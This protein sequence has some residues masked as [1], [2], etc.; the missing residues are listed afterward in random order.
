MSVDEEGIFKSRLPHID[1]E[2]NN[3]IE[4][5]IQNISG[6]EI[7][8][9]FLDDEDYQNLKLAFCT[10]EVD[11]K[12]NDSVVYSDHRD[13]V[14]NFQFVHTIHH[15][16]EFVSEW[17]KLTY[18]ILSNLKAK[19]LL[20]IKANLNVRTPT[21]IE[22]KYHND[23][24]MDFIQTGYPSFPIDTTDHI[25]Y[26]TAIYYV[27]SNDGYTLFECGKKIE[28]VSNRIVIFPGKLKHAGTTCTNEKIRVV[29]NINYI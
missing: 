24:N 20:R 27:N 6:I 29:L 12:W 18:P 25:P 19:V 11:W 21:I 10:S 14:Y 28:S 2:I 23:M 3:D 1:K 5:G 4:P 26:K 22:R 15:N 9:N 7:H 13:H 8:D 16:S 17:S